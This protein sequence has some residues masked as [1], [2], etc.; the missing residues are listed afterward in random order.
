MFHRIGQKFTLGLMTLGK[1]FKP[2]NNVID[3]FGGLNRA[4]NV[5]ICMPNDSEAFNHAVNILD[6]LL[7]LFENAQCLILISGSAKTLDTPPSSGKIL[8]ISQA[9]LNTL[10]VPFKGTLQKIFSVP[11]DIVIDLNKKFDF[12]S[13][14]IC[15]KSTASL[16]ICFND[17]TREDFYNF[18]IRLDPHLSLYSQYQKLIRYLQAGM[19]VIN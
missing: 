3:V 10:G 7:D 6:D 1:R 19:T 9:D 16:K 17:S 2:Q 14:Y 15:H 11:F 4:K 18:E 5:L 8:T 13:T 12:V